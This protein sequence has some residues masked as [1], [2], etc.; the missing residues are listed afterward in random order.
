M[1][2]PSHVAP[3]LCREAASKRVDTC[4]DRLLLE[5]CV[6]WRLKRGDRTENKREDCSDQVVRGLSEDMIKE[7][8]SERQ[9]AVHEKISGKSF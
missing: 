6:L 1:Q 7:L 5:N 3:I 2:T 8:R 9:E 4:I